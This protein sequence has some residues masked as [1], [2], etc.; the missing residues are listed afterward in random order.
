M[1]S[2]HPTIDN[3]LTF[4]LKK[5]QKNSDEILKKSGTI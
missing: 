5:K 2:P 4:Q 3:P 1:T